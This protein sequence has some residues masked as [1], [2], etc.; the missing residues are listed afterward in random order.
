LLK[1]LTKVGLNF[2]HFAW[3]R[4]K[5]S[6]WF[7]YTQK[8][9]FSTNQREER[10]NEILKTLNCLQNLA[11]SFGLFPEIY[12]IFNQISQNF[13]TFNQISWYK[14]FFIQF[15]NFS[16]SLSMFLKVFGKNLVSFRLFCILEISDLAMAIDKEF[17]NTVTYE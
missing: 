4:V 7:I 9:H 10:Y 11:K 14:T 3:V 8:A 13:M 15:S 17:N 6:H 12:N 16:L 1:V 2:I 5:R